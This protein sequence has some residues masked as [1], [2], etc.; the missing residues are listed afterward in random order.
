VQRYTATQAG[1]A[2]L[3]FIALMF[4]LSRWSGGLI[5]R[6]GPT[7]PLV[8][9]P[10]I[11]ACGFALLARAANG[12]SYWSTFFPAV[13]VLGMGMAI[14]VAPLTTTVMSSVPRE[15]AGIASGINNAVSRIGGLLAIAAFGVV[16][17]SVFNQSLDVRLDRLALTPHTR[18]AV[19]RQRPKLAAVETTDPRIRKAVAESLLAGYGVV[20]WI[21]AGLAVGSSLTAAILIRAEEQGEQG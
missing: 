20:L 1:A 9:G 10:L 17:V 8:V 4:L 12:A 16:M 11:A 18:A 3:P 13:L 6:F 5:G 2:L 14:S 21:C 19:D 7:R 15:R